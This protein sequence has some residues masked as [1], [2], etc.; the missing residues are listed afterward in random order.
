MSNILTLGSCLSIEVAEALN[1]LNPKYIRKSSVQHVR[2]DVFVD[3]YIEKILN[4][5]YRND[6]RFKF[7]KEFSD[8]NVLDNQLYDAC[9]GKSLPRIG[10]RRSLQNPIDFINTSEIHIVIIDNFPDLM[11][12]VFID[13]VNK[14]KIFINKGYVDNL[15]SLEYLEFENDFL[16]FDKAKKAYHTF[17]KFIQSIFPDI[18]VFFIPFPVNLKEN[19]ALQ[20]RAKKF[21]SIMQDVTEKFDNTRLVPLKDLMLEDL[22]NTN[23]IYHFSK[24]TYGVYGEEIYGELEVSSE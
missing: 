14:Q 12:K 18:K 9:L 11:F 20:Q 22:A 3:T 13:D 24:K 21:L 7:K 8:V 17:V 23:D 10:E 16:S 6:I 19:E 2:I 1:L 4:P 5:V 15:D